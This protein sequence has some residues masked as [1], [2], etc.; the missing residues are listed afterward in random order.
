[1]AAGQPNKQ[2]RYVRFIGKTHSIN[3]NHQK[4]SRTLKTNTKNKN[5]SYGGLELAGWLGLESDSQLKTTRTIDF[6]VFVVS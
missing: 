3:Q 2:K 5:N 1:M 6:I 4:T